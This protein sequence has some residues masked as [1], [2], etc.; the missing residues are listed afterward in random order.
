MPPQGSAEIADIDL[1]T[2]PFHL[3]FEQLANLF[4]AA[5][6]TP[7]ARVVSEFQK[8]ALSSRQPS[9]L[10]PAETQILRKL[11]LSLPQIASAQREF[12][13]VDRHKLARHTRAFIRVT[14]T[15]P[16]RGFERNAS[17]PKVLPT[18]PERLAI[19]GGFRRICGSSGMR[20]A[21]GLRCTLRIIKVNSCRS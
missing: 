13:K 3:S 9:E 6:G 19:S 2:I 17:S 5:D 11:K 7:L 15:S 4:G 14:A 1:A 20:S 10:S 12:E 18:I 16:S 21:V 8:R